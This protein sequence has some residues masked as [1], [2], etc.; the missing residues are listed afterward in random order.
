MKKLEPNIPET[1]PFASD[2]D[3]TA[4]VNV[5]P[6]RLTSSS[7]LARNATLNLVAEGW[8]FLVLIVAMPKLVAFLGEAAFGLF[9]LAWVVIGYLAFLDVGVNRAATKFVSE[10]LARRDDGSVKMVVRT[11]F[12][13]NLTL[14]LVGG[15][16]IAVAAPYLVHLFKVSSNFEGQARM[17]FYAVALA[18]PVLLVQGIFR[19][20]LSSYQRFAWINSVNAIAITLQ[21]SLAVLLAWKGFGVATVVFMTVMARILATAAYGIVLF[22]LMPQIDWFKHYGPSVLPRLLRFG[23]WVSVSQIIGPVLIYLDRMLIASFVSLAAV[24]LYTVPY[25]VMS[26]LRVIPS[27]LMSTLYPA[28]SERGLDGQQKNLHRL[29][30]R[31]I[32]YLLVLL[33]PGI[34]FLLVFGSDVLTLWM[35]NSFAR[36]TVTVLEILALGVLANG[37][38]FVPYNMLQAVGRPDLTGKFHLLELPPYIGLCLFLIPRWGITGAAL[39]STIR[40]ALDATL[41]FWAVSRFCRCS[42][43]N[44]WTSSLRATLTLTAA[45]AIELMI[46]REV[47]PAIWVR[48]GTGVA[49]LVIYFAIVWI[50]IV[51]TREKPAFTAAL[52]MV[53]SQPAA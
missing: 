43:M 49:S 16:A 20:V 23:S 21:W 35:G 18:V 17:T 38:A 11:A 1:N 2:A 15:L 27:S 47:V 31:S 12:I 48:L 32:R 7:L 34:I 41:L 50:F 40:L 28:F 44:L 6:I 24:T 22:K 9:S 4:D 3:A 52:R 33:M 30:E 45:L 53:R 46:I 19:A 29:F 42:L 26:R 39:A 10:H 8:T 14:G 5:V 13:A 25:E 36:Q 37:I 51:E